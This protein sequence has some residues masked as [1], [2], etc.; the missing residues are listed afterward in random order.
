MTTCAA[1]RP[2]A[3]TPA[4]IRIAV[5]GATLALAAC[6]RAIN[7]TPQPAPQTYE[8]A[9]PPHLLGG[10]TSE[11]A[12]PADETGLLGGPPAAGAEGG[13]PAS[14]TLHFRRPDGVVVSTMKTI[15]DEPAQA[16][17]PVH[18]RAR[19]KG[20]VS[21]SGS[22]RVTAQA[23]TPPPPLV[24][25]T[26]AQ[27][28]QAPPPAP[29]ALAKAPQS[30]FDHALPLTP[31]ADPKLAALQGAL[32]A[33][34]GA[35]GAKLAV[36]EAVTQGKPGG[37]DLRLPANLLARL[38][39]EAAKLGLDAAARTAEVSAKLSGDGYKI[40]PEGPITLP[41]KADQE[42]I[43]NWRVTPG[44]GA[45]AKALKAEADLALTGDGKA[46]TFS[47]A[48]LERTPAPPSAKPASAQGQT[49]A[50]WALAIILILMAVLVLAGVWRNHKD[51][52]RAEAERRQRKQAAEAFSED[53]SKAAPAQ[54]PEPTAS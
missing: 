45:A 24:S 25:A 13:A 52:R 26:P 17:P 22:M 51:R 16:A 29:A 12:K 36:A 10:E 27:T 19:V 14:A 11:A 4:T 9:P 37:V 18:R 40:E 5:L 44:E 46:Q 21:R 23:V 50:K 7:P 43:F 53:E 48:A 15:P 8:Q 31:P 32:A 33:P 35:A 1:L 39:A 2:P 28:G 47:L 42:I 30:P 41:L 6:T 34:D 20:R 3:P 38:K 54:E 49:Q